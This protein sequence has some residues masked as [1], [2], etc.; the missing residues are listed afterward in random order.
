[1]FDL[2][3]VVI[4]VCMESTWR[5]LAEAAGREPEEVLAKMRADAGYQPLERGDITIDEYY[6]HVMGLLGVRIPF[7]EFVRC[8]NSVF[9]GV[10]ADV[11]P[12]LEQVGRRLRLVALT[13]TNACHATAWVDMFADVLTHFERVFMSHEMACRKPEPEC[14]GQVLDY[15]ALAPQQVVFIDDVAENVRGA[16]ALGMKGIVAAG[17]ETVADGFRWLG[18]LPADAGERT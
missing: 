10:T 5:A 3:G 18:V 12:L 9:L 17:T 4:D 6:E 13:N 8:W 1:M 2:G 16:E 14:F 11:E 7:D 15:L